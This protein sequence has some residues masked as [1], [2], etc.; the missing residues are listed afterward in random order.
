MVFELDL[1]YCFQ[2]VILNWKTISS[3]LEFGSQ[4][5]RLY[6]YTSWGINF[7][8][9]ILSTSRFE[10]WGIALHTTGTGV[11]IPDWAKLARPYVAWIIIPCWVNKI[12]N[13]KAWELINRGFVAV[14]RTDPNICIAEPSP[15]F[16]KAEMGTVGLG[17]LWNVA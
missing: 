1:N 12:K 7:V 4:L 10:G 2:R 15:L 14:L 16:S 17:P 8:L 11:R 5:E 3:F 13:M 6:L 9:F